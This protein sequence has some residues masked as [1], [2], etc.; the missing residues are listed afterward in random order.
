MLIASDPH[1]LPAV[2]SE[3]T[4][5]EAFQRYGGGTRTNARP[6]AAPLAM[7]TVDTSWYSSESELHDQW[8]R[9]GDPPPEAVSRT[10]ILVLGTFLQSSLREL[11]RRGR[12][13]G[14]LVIVPQPG[15]WPGSDSFGDLLLRAEGLGWES[16]ELCRD[17]HDAPESFASAS[18]PDERPLL[19]L[20]TYPP[21]AAGQ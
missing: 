14:R 7:R 16:I 19:I 12:P 17:L 9:L 20:P 15:H 1:G 21:A 13:G 5:S 11:L 3:M 18:S 6:V 4:L 8:Q 10:V 2:N